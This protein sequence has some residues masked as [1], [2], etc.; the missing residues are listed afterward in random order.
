MDKFSDTY[1]I[2]E[3]LGEGTGGIV[4]KA[5]HKRLKKE[6]VIKKLRNKSVDM[7]MNRQEVD[8]LKNL[9]HMYLPQ[10]LDFLIEDGEIYTVMSYIPGK[11]FK[12][13]LEEGYTY[14]QSELTRWGMQLCSALNYLHSQNPPIIHSDIKP[15]NIMLTQEGNICL[16]D[17]NISFFLDD[18]TVLGYTD[19][20]TSPEQYIIALDQESARSLPQYSSIDE[21]SDIYSVGATFYHLITGR[22]IKNYKERPD[23]A[24]LEEKV[25]ETFANIIVKA[26]QI[27]PED[28]YANAF[29]MFQEFQGITKKDQRYQALLRRQRVIRIGLVL[30]LGVFIITGGF[31][32][33]MIKVEKVEK[34]NKLVEK[35]TDY[36]KDGDYENEEKMHGEAIDVLPS[37]LES[38]Y[39]EAY[40]LYEQREYEECIAF[41]DYDILENERLGLVDERMADVYYLRADSCFELEDYE[42]AV[43]SYEHLFKYGGFNCEYYRDYAIAL[44]YHADTAKAQ[45]VLEDAIEYGLTEDSIYYAKGEIEKSMRQMESACEEFE[46]CIDV[47]EDDKLKARAYV[48]LSKIYEEENQR[49]KERKVLLEARETLP[50]GNQMLILERLIQ[51]DIELAEE[52]G[53]A[54]YR[55][56]AIGL[57]NEVI[58]Q[59]W[60]TYTTYNNLAILNEKQGYLDRA[61]EVLEKMEKNFGADYNIYKRYAFLE[62][63]RQELKDNLQ[64]DYSQFAKY[65]EQAMQMYAEWQKDNDT[66]AEMGLLEN[67][68]QQVKAGGW[69]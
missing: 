6:V 11:S 22:K 44:A 32:I 57:L 53:R 60:D 1:V 55:D 42:N 9:H 37:G 2:L 17:F 8:I 51:V 54:D 36:R 39:Q 38:Y 52:K 50:I 43:D 25:S 28:R 7:R 69:L 63:D 46:Q 48:M 15:A 41:I 14:S 12:Q 62:I 64:R 26:L 27:D 24:C 23:L 40:S 66:D 58:N 33:H 56:E 4:Y 68:Y 18:T 19:G 10:V 31:G 45:E 21:K 5:Y 3:K 16:I 61:Q 65:Y 20:Y 34:Y 59:G 30:L 35:Q 47:T 13:L 67:A 49:E 29:E